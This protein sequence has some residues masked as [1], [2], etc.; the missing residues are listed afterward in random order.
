MCVYVSA[1]T[2]SDIRML[3]QNIF[4]CTAY[5]RDSLFI[6]EITWRN[7]VAGGQTNNE[8]FSLYVSFINSHRHRM[9][10]RCAMCE[11]VA[12]EMC[13]HIVQQLQRK[14]SIFFSVFG[15]FLY[16]PS[17]FA[18]HHKSAQK[19]INYTFFLSFQCKYATNC[20]YL[21][22]LPLGE[23][24]GRMREIEEERERESDTEQALCPFKPNNNNNVMPRNKM[25]K[26]K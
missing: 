24:E 21:I 8:W 10:T 23:W 16:R 13:C 6:I 25:I 15:L 9:A 7:G 17:H 4:R 14:N 5:L 26:Q 2:P 12:L 1:S 22:I 19:R 20:S 11:S 18:L 3:M